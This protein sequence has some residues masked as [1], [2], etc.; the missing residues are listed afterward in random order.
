MEFGVTNP[1]LGDFGHMC[2]LYSINFARIVPMSYIFVGRF[3][4]PFLGRF[5]TPESVTNQ[6][7]S[8]VWPSRY[9]VI[10]GKGLAHDPNVTSM[11]LDQVYR[12]YS[13]RRSIYGAPHERRSRISHFYGAC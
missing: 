6:R 4:L 7:N 9:G 2:A 1:D 10:R 13:A 5:G 11:A 8:K 3:V 12:S